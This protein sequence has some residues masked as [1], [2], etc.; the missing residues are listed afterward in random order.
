MSDEGLEAAAQSAYEDVISLLEQVQ[1]L[2]TENAQLRAELAALREQEP[3]IPDNED[4]VLVPR[5]LIGAACSAI[6]HKRDAPKTLAEL[7]RYTAGDMAAPQPTP[8]DKLDAEIDQLI[9]ERDCWEE[10]ATALAERVGEHFGFDV[11]EHSSMNCP[12]TN[13]LEWK[14][15]APKPAIPDSVAA[16]AREALGQGEPTDWYEALRA[17][18]AAQQEG[19]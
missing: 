15:P 5:G 8:D 3:A 19:K 14:W 1:N 7:R 6:N 4:C 10:K 12:V 17:M 13:A 9:T 11:G 16:V 2:E 18:L